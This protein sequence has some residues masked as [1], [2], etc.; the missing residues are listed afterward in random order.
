[1]LGHGDSVLLRAVRNDYSSLVRCRNINVVIT[2]PGAA[3]DLKCCGL[4]QKSCRDFCLIT[5]NQSIDTLD[6]FFQLRIFLPEVC[7]CVYEIFFL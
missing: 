5:D 3:D 6:G 7:V 1:M 4:G 2:H